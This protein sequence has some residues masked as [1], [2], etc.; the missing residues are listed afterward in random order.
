[1]GIRTFLTTTVLVQK[2]TTS[3]NSMGG[4]KQT[5]STRIAALQCRLK[6]SKQDEVEVYGKMTV[7]GLWRLYCVAD[8]DGLS[9]EETDRIVW[10]RGSTSKTY[11][12]KSIYNPGQLDR[13]MEIDILEIL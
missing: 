8:S 1:M 12:V 9:I 6:R 3:R 11:Q 4:S 5:F 10:T 7:T 13:H 2:R